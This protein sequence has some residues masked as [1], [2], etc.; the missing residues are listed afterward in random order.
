M[1]GWLIY[2][3]EW[4]RLPARCGFDELDMQIDKFRMLRDSYQTQFQGVRPDPADDEIMS[5]KALFSKNRQEQ[6]V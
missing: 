5:G 4:C 1:R 2:L 3:A 6:L